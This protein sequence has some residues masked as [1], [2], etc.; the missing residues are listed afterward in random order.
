M[1]RFMQATNFNGFVFY[2]TD[3]HEQIF[4]LNSRI[5]F[6]SISDIFV[7][8]TSGVKSSLVVIS[9]KKNDT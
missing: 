4:I 7:T 6:T 2:D 8:K 1:Q 9:C 5:R 3:F